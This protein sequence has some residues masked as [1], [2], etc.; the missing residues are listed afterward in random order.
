MLSKYFKSAASYVIQ[1][2]SF[3]CI[4]Y[5]MNILGV[6]SVQNTLIQEVKCTTVHGFP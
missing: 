1:I 3:Y 4:L 6:P 5:N 2:T